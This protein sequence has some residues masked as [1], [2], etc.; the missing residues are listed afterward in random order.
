MGSAC[1]KGAKGKYSAVVVGGAKCKVEKA[2]LFR[3]QFHSDPIIL[4]E[5]RQG[6]V[7]IAI[8]KHDK[9]RFA[10][11][12]ITRRQA[13]LPELRRQTSMYELVMSTCQ[14]RHIVKVIAVCLDEDEETAQVVFELMRGGELLDV[15]ITRSE[16][17]TEAVAREIIRSLMQ[18]LQCMHKMGLV[19][20]SVRAENVLFFE[21]GDLSCPK[22]GGFSLA[23]AASDEKPI[24]VAR[25]ATDYMYIAPE[26]FDATVRDKD[27]EAKQDVW[28]SGV[29]F[30]ILLVGR[31]PIDQE[32]EGLD[33]AEMRQA[34][35]DGRINLFP[36][37]STQNL[38]P[39]VQALVRS[40]LTMNPDDRPDFTAL[41]ESQ[42]MRM[43]R[44][45][46]EATHLNKANLADFAERRK[47]LLRGVV[48][49]T[50][51]FKMTA[52]GGNALLASPKQ[53]ST[54]LKNLDLEEED[55]DTETA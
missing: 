54:P 36:A 14:H 17:W 3:T 43:P 23:M 26:L 44:H 50:A 20:R 33:N 19:H 11:R 12:T 30:Y 38:S 25:V 39:G 37:E 41:L 9:K 7:T 27:Q 52:I 6:T 48:K 42:Y 29:L 49:L 55:L 18:A 53:T 35:V 34:I 32:A 28:S 51:A 46:L 4:G 21:P 22:L 31:P 16:A 10:V 24:D 5:G 45:E 8:R 40:M 13:K 1:G 15:I 47:K 2:E